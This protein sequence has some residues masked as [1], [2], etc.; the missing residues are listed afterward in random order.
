MKAARLNSVGTPLIIED[1]E[2]PKP[3][4]RQVLVRVRSAGVCHSDVHYRSGTW[5]KYTIQ[6]LGFQSPP[7]PLTMG[8]EIAGV[9]EELGEDV[10]NLDTKTP[11]AINPWE[12]EGLCHYCSI[13][14]EQMCD[15]PSRLGINING[16]YAE[17]VLV[18]DYRYLKV[19]KNLSF[20]EAAPLTCSGVT[21]YRAL[22]ETDISPSKSVIIIGSG[23]GLGTLAIKLGK[24]MGITSLIGVDVNDEA[25]RLTKNAGAD[26]AINAI[27]ESVEKEIMSITNGNGADGIID[28]NSSEKTLAIY[29]KL[30]SKLGTYVMVGQFGSQL[31]INA[32]TT[33][34]KA[35]IFR[36][37]FTGNNKDFVEV[38]DLAEKGHIIPVTKYVGGLNK[39]NESLDKLESLK[40]SGRQI[41]RP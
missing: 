21:T 39:L 23:G 1:V 20:D 11:V 40:V 14:E 19:I 17:F 5:G 22:K 12:G 18:P 34:R 10:K 24:A 35:Q 2:V 13:G 25:I 31:N 16:G 27:S 8:H 15:N 33:V 7:L 6:S 36:G 30:L 29:P 37:T 4:G 26:F 32:I 28:L 9:I 3:K 38:M 41:I